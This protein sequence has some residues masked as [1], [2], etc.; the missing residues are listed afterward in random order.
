MD[1]KVMVKSDHLPLLYRKMK[2]VEE[3]KK[4][5][6]KVIYSWGEEERKKYKEL[7]KEKKKVK[8]LYKL[9]GKIQTVMQKKKIKIGKKRRRRKMV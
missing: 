2:S 1:V 5:E 7:M 4:M 6:E 3:M 9:K 8:K